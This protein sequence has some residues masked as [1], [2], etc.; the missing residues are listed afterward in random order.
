MVFYYNNDNRSDD[1][2]T[3]DLLSSLEFHTKCKLTPLVASYALVLLGIHKC[4]P[5]CMCG[6]VANFLLLC[7][8]RKVA[9]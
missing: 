1:L 2:L 7:N 8:I 3:H 4:I 6:L 5:V 9:K